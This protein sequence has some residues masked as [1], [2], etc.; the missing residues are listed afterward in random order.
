MLLFSL[1]GGAS[2]LMSSLSSGDLRYLWCENLFASATRTGEL[3][4]STSATRTG[5]LAISTTSRL[6]P[7][8]SVRGVRR[9]VRRNLLTR[10]NF[11]HILPH[12]V[13][14][15]NTVTAFMSWASL[16]AAHIDVHVCQGLQ[17]S[18][19]TT[20]HTAL[21]IRV[22]TLGLRYHPGLDIF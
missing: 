1:F 15:R 11:L 22:W 13:L 9:T 4:I 16:Y 8:P 7:Q 19:G 20:S 14:C 10:R 2:L 21:L 6:I 5:E 18:T 12:S 17:Y 3:A